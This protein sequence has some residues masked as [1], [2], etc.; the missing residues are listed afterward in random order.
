MWH[1][2]VMIL[3]LFSLFQASYFDRIYSQFLIECLPQVQKVT[4]RD[5]V[6]CKGILL[7][8]DISIC[9]G[10]YQKM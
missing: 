2:G 10:S 7:G 8:C 1:C 4:E 9:R 6:N 3:H 5:F